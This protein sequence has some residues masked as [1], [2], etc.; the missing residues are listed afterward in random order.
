[1][2]LLD[3]TDIENNGPDNP[4][5]SIW[6]SPKQT[7]QWLLNGNTNQITAIVLIYIGGVAYGIN[8]AEIKGLGYVKEASDIFLNAI[9]F[10]GLG[11]LAVYSVLIWAID[12]VAMWL[13]G[14]GGV[15][16]TRTVFAWAFI[17]TIASLFLKLVM[18]IFIGDDMF[19]GGVLAENEVMRLVYMV[20]GGAIL[21][22]EIWHFILL[23]LLI[24]VA[25]KLSFGNS[26]L[27]LIGG[28]L[29][30][31][32]PLIVLVFGLAIL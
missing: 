15:K 7:A 16:N 3:E 4:W 24:G 25:Q 23:I 19:R 1:M 22:L 29:V 30:I 10:S 5:L 26:F 14:K 13:G 12:F 21:A 11:G 28:F 31:F 32:V 27:S 9:I 20:Y 8:Q 2:Q 18:Y 6:L 17:P